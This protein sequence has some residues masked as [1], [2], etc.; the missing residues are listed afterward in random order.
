MTLWNRFLQVEHLGDYLSMGGLL[1]TVAGFTVTLIT[2]VKAKRAADAAREAAESAAKEIR[3]VDL[4]AEIATILQQIEELK[5]LQ[6]ANASELLADRYSGLR[7]KLI[8]VRESSFLAGEAEQ[9]LIQDVIARV[10]A[11]QKA[12]DRDGSVFE[13]G[14]RVARSNESLSM[15]V[16]SM[17]MM[18]ERLKNHVSVTS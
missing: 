6:R 17:T 4:V 16:D 8:A 3:K 2:A 12:L 10:A 14:R 9:T 15:C 7:A 18:S 11:L 5:R 1:L 13:D